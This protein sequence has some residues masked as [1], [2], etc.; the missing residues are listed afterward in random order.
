MDEIDLPSTISLYQFNDEANLSVGENA[1]DLTTLLSQT[2]REPPPEKSIK[3]PGHHDELVYIYTSG[4]TGLPKA[5][6]ISHSRYIY[7]TAA[8]AR[9]AGFTEN[10][11][12]YSPLPMY[13]TACGIMSIGQSIIFGSTVIIRKKFSASAYFADCAKYQATVKFLKYHCYLTNLLELEITSDCSV[14]WWNV[15]L[16]P[17]YTW[18]TKW[19]GTQSSNGVWKWTETTNMASIC[20][21][22]Q[23]SQSV[24]VLWCNWRKRKHCQ[25]R[26]VQLFVSLF[27]H[28]H[29]T[30]Q[31]IDK[32]LDF[33]GQQY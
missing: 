28:E 7:I 9:L 32:V 3:K 11:T 29:C 5:A 13:H 31:T 16:L 20:E 30:N 10:D 17:L 26:S 6:V 25:H 1:K 15:P 33:F 12:F 2:T 23:Y 18:S 14:Y 27:S 22:I 8:I 21:A 24:R 19:Q 4:T